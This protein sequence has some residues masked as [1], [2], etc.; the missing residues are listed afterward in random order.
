[1]KTRLFTPGPV[2]IPERILRALSV[3]PPHHRTD[4][5]RAVMR[6]VT[7]ALQKLH[8]TRGEV[9]ILAA[10]GT[11]AMEA[12][13]VNLMAPGA[14]ALAVNG[15]KFGERWVRLLEAWGV[16]HETIAVEW[17]A[18]VEPAA[19]ED[20]LRRDP[21]LGTVFVTH[22]ETSTGA[23]HDVQAIAALTRSLG[24]RLVVDAVTSLG[25]HPLEQDAWG[26]D[27]VVCGSQKGLMLPPGLATV[28][29]APWAAPAIDGERLPRFY[30]DLRRAR[31][32]LPS[33]ETPWTPPVSL[34]LALE[35]ALTMILEE[36]G[37]SEVHARHRRL[38]LAMRAGGEALGFRV[39]SSSPS[40]SVTALV[41]PEGVDASAL[42]K[43]LRER[44]GMV[45]AGGQD[46]LKGRIV[47]VGHMGAY[48]LADLHA[49]IGALG[50]CVA[51]LQPGHRAEGD[52]ALAAS[53]A[54]N[55]VAG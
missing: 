45:I 52:A 23:I 17:G 49:L 24:R 44:H 26:V 12:A 47:R 28:S 36:Q 3:P 48:D 42:V 53:R 9:F 55:Q 30:F 25:V 1:M 35:E 11:G 27:V 22:S 4:A 46:H 38:A 21:D 19:I 40:N 51:E 41:P 33:G 14:R 2:E 31:K 29:I 20:L 8:L 16:P 34:V 13:V 32:A 7:A 18:A 50:S 39:F 54:W 6:R 5:F 43:R 37:L 15:G 10:S